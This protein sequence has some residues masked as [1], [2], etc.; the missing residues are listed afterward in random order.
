MAQPAVSRNYLKPIECGSRTWRLTMIDPAN[1]NLATMTLSALFEAAAS[2]QPVP[3][4]GCISAACGY[5]GIGLLLKSIRIS[6][7]KQTA[8]T[9]YGVIEQRLL[10]QSVKLLSFAQ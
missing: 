10:D 7:R 4:G 6:A 8:D 2:T 3:G 9:T 5:L 1:Q